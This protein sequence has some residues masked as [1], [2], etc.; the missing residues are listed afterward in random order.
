MSNHTPP[1]AV[2][3]RQPTDHGGL[4]T[5]APAFFALVDGFFRF[6]ALASGNEPD[7]ELEGFRKLAPFHVLAQELMSPP[8]SRAEVWIDGRS[9]SENE[10]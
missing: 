4:I 2:R 6:F 1:A 8:P 10:S 7:H 3:L 9:S 5:R